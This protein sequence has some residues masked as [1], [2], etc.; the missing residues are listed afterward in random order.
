[1]TDVVDVFVVGAGMA[2]LAAAEEA[3]KRGLSVAIAEE[4]MFGG[5]VVNVNHLSPPIEGLSAAGS[6][7]AADAMTRVSDLGA[8]TLFEAVTGCEA[9]PDGSLQVSTAAGAHAARTVIIATGAKLRSLGV[10]GEQEFEGRGVSHCADCDAPMFRDETVLV[11][12]GGDS[13][14]QESLVL[15]EFCP[16]VHL[17]HRGEAFA[18]R[19]DFVEAVRKDPRIKVHLRT[20]VEALEGGKALEAAKLRDTTTGT[21][22]RLACKGFFAY[23]GLEPNLA[24]I[25]ASIEL[26]DGAV[27]VDEALESSTKNVFAI[28]AVRNGYGGQIADTMAD[29]SRAIDAICKRLGRP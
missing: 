29:A 25:P 21:H 3:A 5:L 7:L 12:G 1:M 6:D 15:A 17:V 23:V 9:G 24:A 18:A 26:Q 28:G 16:T 10:P 27:R 14:L 4:M 22:Q 8:T 20:V 2:G 11:V 13:A 19:S